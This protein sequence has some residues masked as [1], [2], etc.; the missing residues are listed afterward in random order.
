MQSIVSWIRRLPWWGRLIAWLP[1]VVVIW[2]P[3]QIFSVIGWMLAEM[4]GQAKTKAKAAIS[5]LLWPI[6]ILGFLGL[7]AYSPA[8][9][10]TVGAPILMLGTFVGCLWLMLYGL[11]LMASSMLPNS[12]RS[13]KKKRK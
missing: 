11:W 13:K 2:L 12:G 10:A 3:F 4:F 9:Q 7:L 8:A 1:F 5:P 6:A